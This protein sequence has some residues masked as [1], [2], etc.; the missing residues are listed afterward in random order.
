MKA[1]FDRFLIR[2]KHGLGRDII[3]PQDLTGGQ[4]KVKVEGTTI[5]QVI[6][7]LEK[8]YPGMKERLV[9]NNEVKPAFSIVIDGDI[10][11]ATMLDPVDENNEIAFLP[12]ISGGD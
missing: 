9:E 10:T 4:R 1:L 11:D 3:P 12:A 6:N 5:R 2:V 7:N 8:V